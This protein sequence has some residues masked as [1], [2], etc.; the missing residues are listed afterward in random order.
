MLN[1]KTILFFLLFILSCDEPAIF[2]NPCDVYGPA[3]ICPDD[4]IVCLEE[5]CPP[6]QGCIDNTACNYDEEAEEDDESCTYAL[7]N[8]DCLE[9]CCTDTPNTQTAEDTSLICP[10]GAITIDCFG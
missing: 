9:L 4:S 7:T 10:D 1:F 3:F 6:I 8:Y 5:E 2:N